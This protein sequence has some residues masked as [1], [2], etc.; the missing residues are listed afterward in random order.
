MRVAYQVFGSGPLAVVTSG[1]PASHLD[2]LWEE[3]R[4]RRWHE[5]LASFARVA[6]FDRRGT[7]AS[8][9]ADG[10]PTLEQYTEDLG[11]VM[12]ACGFDRAALLGGAEAARMCALFAADHPE[13][14]SAL[15]LTGGSARGDA[16]LAPERVSALEE[17][18]ETAWGRGEIIA[19]LYAPSMAGDERFRRW[20]ARMERNAVSPRAARELVRLIADSDVRPVLSRI[21]APTLV[22]HRREDTLVPIA[23]GRALAQAIP[24]ARFV[25]FEGRDNMAWVGDAEPMLD[26]IE[27]FLTGRRGEHEPERVLATILFT[28]IVG[29]TE[30]AARLTD[31]RWRD[32]LAEHDELVRREIER[33]HG[34]PIKSTGD[35]FLA[36]FPTPGQ[37]IRAAHAAIESTAAVGLRVRAGVHTG[38]VELFDGDIGGV[39]V[40]IAARIAALAPPSQTIVSR[41]V[42]DILIGS[43]LSLTSHGTH[44]LKGVPGRWTLY[45]LADQ[46]TSR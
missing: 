40:H 5:R 34:R 29:S 42:K 33:A 9:P 35:G 12:D 39:A 10:P 14:V 19:G 20:A 22:T 21:R 4:V 2:V 44:T 15:V 27:E 30:L 16:G 26:E 32:L 3:P 1:G 6:I 18:I 37:A 31:R 8:D 7:G 28:D 17:L 46:D 36:T 11:A 38:E 45:A 23:E 24:G 43:G 25:E 41:T 13:R